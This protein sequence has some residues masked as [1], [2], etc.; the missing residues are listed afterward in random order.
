[1]NALQLIAAIDELHVTA[2]PGQDIERGEQTAG[3]NCNR[4]PIT[5]RRTGRAKNIGS[6][7]Q[8]FSNI[9][10]LSSNGAAADA[11]TE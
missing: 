10:R 6:K 7:A 4:M 2:L 8:C 1:V 5:G 3:R 11:A 9:R